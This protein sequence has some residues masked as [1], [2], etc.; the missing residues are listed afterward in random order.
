MCEEEDGKAATTLAGAAANPE[1]GLGES[2]FDASTMSLRP[3]SLRLDGTGVIKNDILCQ[4]HHVYRFGGSIF[5]NSSITDGWVRH[6]A[7][8]E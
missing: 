7:V 5:V 8:Q 1:N 3:C 2:P 6:R 4:V